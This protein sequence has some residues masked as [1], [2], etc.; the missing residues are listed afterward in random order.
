MSDNLKDTKLY[1]LGDTHNTAQFVSFS[2]Q[3]EKR[4]T[5]ILGEER[6]VQDIPEN[7]ISTLIE[8]S[9]EKAVNI[10]TFTSDFSEA[11]IVQNLKS[12]GEVVEN[13]NRFAAEGLYTLINE[14]IDTNDS[15]ILGNARGSILEFGPFNSANSLKNCSFEIVSG[16][17]LLEKIY[18]FLPNIGRP[19]SDKLQWS[20][21]SV[22]K[23]LK[24]ENTIIWETVV[25][26]EWQT[27][28]PEFNYPNN[29]SL[30]L[31]NKL[32]GLL[33]ADLLGFIVPKTLV[34]SRNVPPFTFGVET[35]SKE[36]FMRVA[37]N[38]IRFNAS[39]LNKFGWLD[40]FK[41][42]QEDRTS[43]IS[44]VLIQDKIIEKFSGSCRIENNKPKASSNVLI[45]EEL[46][47]EVIR[48]TSKFRKEIPNFIGF[49][50]IFGTNHIVYLTQIYFESSPKNDM[51]IL[52]EIS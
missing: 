50:W 16:L 19:F 30:F 28:K 38:Q 8:Q 37:A 41:L 17:Q 35:F 32:Y 9:E 12:S 7:Y 29:F 51:I 40:P 31:G 4:Y 22:K 33:I 24:K 36:I 23:G 3:I 21:H 2:P 52:S 5:R 48:L 49:D 27:V 47:R 20:I 14:K 34:F 1:K 42:L 46:K 6:L 11:P 15:G 18:G 26:P 45:P 10:S 43:D 13:I 44:S 39:A 25:D